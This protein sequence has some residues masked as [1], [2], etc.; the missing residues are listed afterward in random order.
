MY[1]NNLKRFMKEKEVSGFELFRRTNIAPST[2]SGI[3]NNRILPFPGW[4]KRISAA[5]D[6]PESEIFPDERMG[7]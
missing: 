5:L 4:K 1:K 6:I 3:V 2:I 7:E